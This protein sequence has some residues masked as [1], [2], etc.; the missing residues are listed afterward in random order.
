MLCFVNKYFSA[1]QH[2]LQIMHLQHGDQH[3]PIS[4]NPPPTRRIEGAKARLLGRVGVRAPGHE[5][6]H[7][8][9]IFLVFG[10]VH[11]L[12]ILARAG[13]M[14][15]LC[16]CIHHGVSART[17]NS[18]FPISVMRDS[19]AMS[20][21]NH[22]TREPSSRIRAMRHEPAH[23]ALPSA[24]ACS[25]AHDSSSVSEGEPDETGPSKR[26]RFLGP[27]RAGAWRSVYESRQIA[28]SINARKPCNLQARSE[29]RGRFLHIL[30][31]CSCS[32]SSELHIS[33][34]WR[35]R[36]LVSAAVWRRGR[37]EPEPAAVDGHG[38]QWVT[39]GKIKS[40]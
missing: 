30:W 25:G 21:L 10:H 11:V 26:S 38:G 2:L 9:R 18:Q 15:L 32:S 5:A 24:C 17:K 13:A 29:S 33:N 8:G 19:R 39:S 37:P 1:L 28:I 6:D 20:G 34:C 36:E 31:P 27:A 23:T 12:F 40:P 7:L 3:I 35:M 22:Y 4:I 16:G 14:H